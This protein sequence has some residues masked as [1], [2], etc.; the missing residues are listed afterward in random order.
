[1]AVCSAASHQFGCAFNVIVPTETAL[2]RRP[3]TCSLTMI[4]EVW[5]LTVNQEDGNDV[6]L[7]W[8]T[9]YEEDCERKDAMK[10]CG[11][12]GEW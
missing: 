10:R 4:V 2:T 11:T 3:P 12:S 5:A 7:Q 8:S 6:M 9:L 1:M